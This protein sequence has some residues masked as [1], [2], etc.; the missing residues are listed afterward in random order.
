MLDLHDVHNDPKRVEDALKARG[1][2]TEALLLFEA[3]YDERR[4]VIAESDNLNAVRN[5]ASREIGELMKAGKR[6]EAEAR[7]AA[8][9]ELKS[10]I[11][12]LDRARDV[13]EADM[14]TLLS[15]LPNIPHASVPIGVDE[16][17]N[18]EVRQWGEA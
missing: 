10:R 11:A 6:D 18:K 5:K 7:R 9:F 15:S 2:P 13:A 4:R 17:A 12:E 16:S 8:V 14:K 1:F 3:A